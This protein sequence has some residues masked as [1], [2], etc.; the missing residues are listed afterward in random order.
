L[1]NPDKVPKRKLYTGEEIPCIGMGTFGSDRFTPEQVAGAVAGAIK[2]GYRL[3]DCASVYGN[4]DIIGKVFAGAIENGTVK[5]KELFI[6]SK[7]W[8]DKH[9]RG[10]V[11][12]SCAKSLKDLQLDY[13]D[14]YFI[15]WPFPNYHAP[16][17]DKD[18]RNPDSKPFS[19][20][21]F[22]AAWRQME[23]LVDIGLVKNIGMSSMTIPKLDAVLPLCRI[24]P[25]LI[26]MELHPSFQQP[27]LF[28]YC[29]KRGI[30]VIGFCPIGSPNRPDRDKTEDDVIDTEIPEIIKIAKAH[31]VHPAIICLKWAVQR[32]QI[33]IP[34]SVHES[35]YSGNLRC[36]T[37]DPLTNA[38]M[39]ILKDADKNCR[40]IKGQVFLWKS[41]K[42]WEDLWD[43]DG[44]ITK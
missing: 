21:R 17:C 24:K 18:A 29:I 31:R 27:E 10:D 12:V 4:E 16:G 6:M 22:I 40:L 20:E 13:L 32:G 11:L 3:F 42:S 35:N 1:I 5:R 30:Q 8:N 14:T 28:H 26:E 39:E 9:G 34:F 41:A 43:L 19:V 15:H 33:P 37:E 2:I 25:A 23:K 38:E 36:T 44:K 7:V